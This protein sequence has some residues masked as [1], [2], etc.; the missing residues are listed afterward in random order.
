MQSSLAQELADAV[1]ACNDGKKVKKKPLFSS[2]SDDSSSDEEDI[3]LKQ[4]L[5]RIDKGQKKIAKK[6][7]KN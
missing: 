7:K 3:D 5:K 4:M 1:L 2:S 6:F